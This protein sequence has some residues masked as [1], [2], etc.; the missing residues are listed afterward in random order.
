MPVMTR[1]QNIKVFE[2]LR[3]NFLFSAAATPIYLALEYCGIYSYTDLSAL[4]ISS[5]D[6]LEFTPTAGRSKCSNNRTT[7]RSAA[8]TSKSGEDVHPLVALNCSG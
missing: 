6:S 8:G 3:E 1:M 7:A 4:L 5:V 2:R